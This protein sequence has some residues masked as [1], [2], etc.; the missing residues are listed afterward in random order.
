MP[1]R[2]KPWSRTVGRRGYKVTVLERVPGG[3]LYLRWWDPT[4]PGSRATGGLGNYRLRSLGHRDRER[5]EK[6][7]EKLAA[8]LLAAGTAARTGRITLSELFARYEQE[9]SVYKKGAQV[10]EDRRR[11]EL[12]RHF[13]GGE[14]DAGSLTHEDLRRF[15][16]LRKAGRISLPPTIEQGRERLR[17]LSPNPSDGTVG[18]DIVFLQAV[19]NWAVRARLLESNPV[20]GFDR[21]RAKNPR[22]PVATYDRY[23]KVR[24]KADDVDP[25]RLFGP[26]LDLIEALGWRVSAIC[27]L[28]ASDVDRRSQPEA[29]Y[30]RIRKRAEVDKEGV[31]M[32][33]PLSESARAAIDLIFERN[34]VIGDGYLFPSPKRPGRPW[35]RWHARD[36]LE[37]AEAAAELEPLEGG[38]FPPYRRAWATA[39]KHLPAQDVAAAGGWRDLRSLQRA[40]QQVDPETLLAVVSEP[41]KLRAA[42]T[43]AM[44]GG[45]GKD[46]GPLAEVASG[47]SS[48]TSRDGR[49]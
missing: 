25:Q 21:P 32:W 3:P 22:R 31:E 18:A 23:L 33:V 45:A 9:V 47:P 34:P 4:A 42:I 20:R 14:R 41:R 11:M 40:Y 36:L 38:D 15:V 46:E 27:Q 2:R 24:E 37:R 49:I 5:G 43:N 6:E 16:R 35:L 1:R 10:R 26:F 39:R 17:R 48:R 7:A 12:W 30:G 29:P 8:E 19:L 13:L 44:T 28:R